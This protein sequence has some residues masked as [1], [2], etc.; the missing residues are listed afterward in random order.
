MPP[1]DSSSAPVDYSPVGA[2]A[3]A[4]LP[5]ASL[6]EYWLR[7][8]PQYR[9]ILLAAEDATLPNGNVDLRKVMEKIKPGDFGL[10]GLQAGGS[11]FTDALV[12]G[13]H[14]AS[15]G[16]GAHGQIAG[17]YVRPN[18]RVSG[19][20]EGELGPA[21]SFLM[22]ERGELYSPEHMTDP[23]RFLSRLDDD[24]HAAGRGT[25]QYGYNK[26][27]L[28]KQTKQ[29]ADIKARQKAWAEYD[30]A[31]K[32]GQK[33]VMPDKPRPTTGE[34]DDALRAR[35]RAVKR[36]KT[37]LDKKNFGETFTGSMQQLS[38]GT[39]R[40]KWEKKPFFD[41]PATQAAQFDRTLQEMADQ[42]AR[43]QKLLE[44]FGARAKTDPKFK[45]LLEDLQRSPQ[46]RL[47]RLAEQMQVRG[48]K[49]PAQQTHLDALLRAA[50]GDPSAMEGLKSKLFKPKQFEVVVPSLLHGGMHQ[51]A[52]NG[53]MPV[54]YAAFAAADTAD[55]AWRKGPQSAYKRF[56]EWLSEFS[57]YTKKQPARDA[58]RVA[59]R[60]QTLF[61]PA[62][63]NVYKHTVAE[64]SSMNP[65]GYYRPSNTKPG[66]KGTL[67]LRPKTNIDPEASKEF[68]EALKAEGV[69]PYD[70]TG[71]GLTALGEVTGINKFRRIFGGGQCRGNHCGAFGPAVYGRAGMGK[72]RGP[73]SSYLPNRVVLNEMFE[74]VLVTHK[75]QMLRDL[76]K[77]GIRRSLAGLGAIGLMGAAGYGLTG[78]AQSGVRS[79]TTPPKP[80]LDP[81]ML[82]N[83]MKLLQP[84]R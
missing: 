68:L 33:P 41:G 63:D 62:A 23:R 11:G 79:L 39:A 64:G 84:K 9:K 82:S 34:I 7:E 18:W 15:G 67:W 36:F 83:A 44:V 1:N 71:A 80:K 52:V 40:T 43:K 58:A 49:T 13:S 46:E 27:R 30:K 50:G 20:P 37:F 57:N 25:E 4:A 59:K 6:L 35:S 42:P 51:T 48:I 32:A 61:S 72:F 60:P 69:K 2:A 12:H 19:V 28:Q 47:A 8:Y 22:N 5:A 53:M 81:T 29:V 54:D 24:M 66:H 31:L 75:S 70:A 74:P 45:T 21:L 55:T 77:G 3:G 76:T 10:S 78:A 14:G 73:P 38:D 17:H 65:K 56:R 16:I 26:A